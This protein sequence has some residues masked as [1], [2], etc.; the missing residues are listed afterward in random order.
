MVSLSGIRTRFTNLGNT[1]RAMGVLG[2][3]A[4]AAGVIGV[5][6]ALYDAHYHAC[7]TAHNRKVTKDADAG[8]D[9]FNN[10]QYLDNGSHLTAKMKNALF[11]YEISH[12]LRG[13]YNATIGYIGGFVSG[14]GRHTVPLV[15][16]V[17]ALCL[18]GKKS[19]VAAAGLCGWGIW[20]TIRHTCSHFNHKQ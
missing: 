4:K 18:N 16:S 1:I 3:G 17:A 14:I 9:Y 11:N 6:A 15:A 5:G 2:V 12:T 19:A 7:L 13:A 8:L 10:T 20:S